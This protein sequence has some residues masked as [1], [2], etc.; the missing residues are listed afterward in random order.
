MTQD[1]RPAS[2]PCLKRQ[3]APSKVVA[4]SLCP[5][6]DLVAL[7]TAD[8]KVTTFRSIEWQ[9]VW[10]TKI[11]KEI[12]GSPT[13]VAWR[14]DG[15]ALVV[16]TSSGRL[17][18]MDVESGDHYASHTPSMKINPTSDSKTTRP[19]ITHVSWVASKRNCAVPVTSINQFLSPLPA[20]QTN[21]DTRMLPRPQAKKEPVVPLN[22][23]QTKALESGV[24]LGP[25]PTTVFSLDEQ[26]TVCL[27]IGGLLTILR[28]LPAGTEPLATPRAAHVTRDLK[29]V[30][31]LKGEG[32]RS[33]AVVIHAKQDRLGSDTT[34][35]VCCALWSLRVLMC[36]ASRALN[37][38]SES[39]AKALSLHKS[40]V[41]DL[42]DRLGTHAP[43]VLPVSPNN[44]AFPPMHSEHSS[45][46]RHQHS[47]VAGAL[48]R[49]LATGMPSSVLET[50][51]AEDCSPARAQRVRLETKAAT[52]ALSSV[53]LTRL[54]PAIS[55]VAYRMSELNTFIYQPDSP[56]PPSTKHSFEN[57]SRMCEQ[58]R[59]LSMA[60]LASVKRESDQLAQ[61]YLW[62][63]VKSMQSQDE[64]GDV[65]EPFDEAIVME[66]L[67]S[68]LIRGSS[69]TAKLFSVEKTIPFSPK[70]VSVPLAKR[71]PHNTQTHTLALSPKF[72]RLLELYPSP[73]VGP[74]SSPSASLSTPVKTG[75]STP[76]LPACMR[77]LTEWVWMLQDS[78][79][80]CLSN[81][82]DFDV[83][84]SRGESIVPGGW[85][86]V[87]QAQ[88]L[89][90]EDEQIGGLRFVVVASNGAA[91]IVDTPP[92]TDASISVHPVRLPT[93]N[94]LQCN[95]YSSDTLAVIH[96]SNASNA[97]P[98]L[99][100]SLVSLA[101]ENIEK[102][103]ALE[104][105]IKDTGE[106]MQDAQ[107]TL[108]ATQSKRGLLMVCAGHGLRTMG[109]FDIE[110]E[111]EEGD[112]E[113]DDQ[114]DDEEAEDQDATMP[115]VS[116]HASSNPH[117]QASTPP[118]ALQAE[119]DE[120]EEGSTTMNESHDNMDMSVDMETDD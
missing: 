96:S 66:T 112:D 56:L 21:N 11:D 28:I 94:L 102:R 43:P 50:F 92:T 79:A 15:R 59:W 41:S 25:T 85:A 44:N 113:A 53:V 81:A 61:L 51:F 111:D 58:L 84:V 80:E 20:P 40:V 90:L 103:R 2:F 110:G 100:L 3:I 48:L 9:R 109:V 12:E 30:G 18:L 54:L 108:V 107:A 13:C 115:Q 49:L 78:M 67:S 1:D 42:S 38:I 86:A 76:T 19:A 95:L 31:I 116:T 101:E 24:L 88:E 16:G 98:V 83:K 34:F 64:E 73:I 114:G 63:Q 68:P 99:F 29:T 7:V 36:H 104:I 47:P 93:R 105:S 27:S 119:A 35:Q 57:A 75:A 22:D 117:I 5:T 23:L 14:P 74:Q 45:Q 52:A 10:V 46:V 70:T 97:K 6:M 69:E 120:E 8:M 72:S 33:C 60:L 77:G 71:H 62:L 106:T 32:S 55:R 65:P 26:G 91:R 37:E 118:Q 87:T 39:W 89:E 82:S 17:V 4:C